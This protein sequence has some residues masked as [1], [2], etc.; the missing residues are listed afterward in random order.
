[1]EWK[2]DRETFLRETCRKAGLE[3]DAWRHGARLQAFTAQ[4]FPEP[5]VPRETQGLGKTLAS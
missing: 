3:D 4:V 1:V 2:W 5:D